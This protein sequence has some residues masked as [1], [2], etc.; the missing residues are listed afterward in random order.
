MGRVVHHQNRLVKQK[1]LK[2]LKYKITP[3]DFS[4]QIPPLKVTFFQHEPNRLGVRLRLRPVRL[5]FVG[6]F[7]TIA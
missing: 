1:R 3:Q 5:R 7:D 2:I 4:L 6:R